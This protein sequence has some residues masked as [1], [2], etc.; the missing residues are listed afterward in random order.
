[1]PPHLLGRVASLDF[2]V[3]IALMPV[4]MALAAPVAGAIG[5]RTTF[6]LAGVLPAVLA[7]AAIV[8]ARLPQDEVAHPLDPPPGTPVAGTEPVASAES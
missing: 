7:V 4:S 6:V 5:L 8:L 3:S 1:M 2:F